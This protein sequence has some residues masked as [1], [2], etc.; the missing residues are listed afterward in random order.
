[1]KSTLDIEIVE[2]VSFQ[3]KVVLA[4]VIPGFVAYVISNS[5][6]DSIVSEES[7]IFSECSKQVASYSVMGTAQG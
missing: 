2:C 6:A 4:E 1:M 3:V 5:R 7:V